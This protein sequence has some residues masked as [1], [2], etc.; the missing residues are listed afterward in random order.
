MDSFGNGEGWME[1]TSQYNLSL[2]QSGRGIFISFLV[3]PF[4]R[5]VA[6]G[7]GGVMH[8]SPISHKAHFLPQGPN[9]DYKIRVFVRGGRIK[10]SLLCQKIH[11]MGSR[12]PPSN[13]PGYLW[14]TPSSFKKAKFGTWRGGS[15]FQTLG[16]N[17]DRQIYKSFRIIF[18][19]KLNPEIQ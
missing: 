4:L 8:P 5:P 1:V 15:F 9:M 13:N 12:N 6:R 11:F 2:S 16:K 3:C 18:C 10:G 17:S 19:L 14:P 7:Y